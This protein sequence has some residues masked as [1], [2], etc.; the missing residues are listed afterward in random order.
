MLGMYYTFVS[1]YNCAAWLIGCGMAHRVRHG[2]EGCGM[3]H[4]DAAWLI[5]V[6]HGSQGAAWLIQ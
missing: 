2:S 5:R 4:K 1:T 6:R 3:A